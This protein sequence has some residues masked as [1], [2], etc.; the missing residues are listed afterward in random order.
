MKKN[1]NEILP[2]LK[3][4]SIA[5]ISLKYS[6]ENILNNPTFRPSFHTY[7]KHLP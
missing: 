4:T 5:K 1:I 2:K 3:L 6:T 7:T